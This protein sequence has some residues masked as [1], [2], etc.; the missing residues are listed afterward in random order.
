M[1]A[2]DIPIPSSDGLTPLGMTLTMLAE[3]FPDRPAITHD[4]VTRT[5]EELETRANRLARA[6]E[7]FGVGQDSF[8]TIGLPN[9]IEFFEA[10]L[11]TYK[12]GAIPQPVSWNLPAAERAAIVELADPALMVGIEDSG[13]SGS[14]VVAAAFEPDQ[15]IPCESLPPRAASSWKAVTSGGSTGRPK[16]IVSTTP[17]LLEPITPL[18]RLFRMPEAGVQLI[19][20]PLYHNASFLTG[21][22]GLLTGNHQ[23]VMSRFDAETFLRLVQRHQVDWAHVVPTMM[24]RIWRLPGEVR[25][26]FDLRSLR[27]LFHGAAPCPVWL[28]EAWIDWLGPDR[29]WEIYAATEGQA[30]T[31]ISGPEWLKHKGSVGRV[32]VGE[33][34]VLGSDDS[35]L[36]PGR[37][38]AI[39]MRRGKDASSEYR[40]IGAEA[41]SKDGGWETHGDLGYF[42]SDGYLYITDREA[43]MILVGG[44]NVYPAE[45]ESALERHPLVASSCVVGLP[46]EDMGNVLHA[47]VQAT[48]SVSNEELLVH[49]REH[50]VTY[51][52]PQTFERVTEPIRGDDGKVRRSSLRSA[53]LAQGSP[54]N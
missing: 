21:I 41:K 26:S 40:Y 31:V 15:A 14:P 33:I 39:W 43:D 36:P 32:A 44:R 23:V 11:A 16:L 29:V 54:A 5:F 1:A 51:K 9:G 48:G 10:V 49:L 47:I 52:L 50:L 24:H 3:R 34:Q 8:V 25:C 4:G 13:R 37:T 2:H 7:Q 12:L 35:E 17:A 18:A 28:K 53:R 42:D 22:I 27:T 20:G 19:A 46:H 30:G 38:G 45:I 6:Y